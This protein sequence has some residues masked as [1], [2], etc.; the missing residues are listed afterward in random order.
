L[1][2]K[3]VFWR[4][5]AEELVW[6][7]EGNTN[8][9]DLSDKKIRIWD[10]NASREF[11]DKIGLKDR[12]EW[13]LGPVYGFQWRHFG[14]EYKTMHDSY[15]GQGVDQLAS[16]I[17]QIK[18]EPN[19]RRMVMIAWNPSAL[20]EM[21]LPPCH[22]MAQFYVTADKRLSCQMYQ[23]SCDMGLG[24]PFNIASYSLLTCML[25]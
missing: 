16:I 25:A 10:G 24:I 17:N 12:E 6:F 23:R 19:S 3:D 4:G 15:E 18:N 11:L 9:K 21:A 13:D 14:A 7:C 22:I 20:P 5:V 8:A 1:T 2:T